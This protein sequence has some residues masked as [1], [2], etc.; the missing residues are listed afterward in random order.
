MNNQA[1]VVI[2][3]L[4]SASLNGN[5][6]PEFPQNLLDGKSGVNKIETQTTIG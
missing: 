6:V 5:N 4:S 3:V 2:M 1:R